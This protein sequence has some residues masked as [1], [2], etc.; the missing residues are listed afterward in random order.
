[1]ASCSLGCIVIWFGGFFARFQ[2]VFS[3]FPLLYKT[4]L[5]ATNG[6]CDPKGWSVSEQNFPVI[7]GEL[8]LNSQ[9][10][11][12]KISLYYAVNGS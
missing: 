3:I 4:M 2:N 12:A 1:M 10:I 7:N 11:W 6:L 5:P 8:E 9:H